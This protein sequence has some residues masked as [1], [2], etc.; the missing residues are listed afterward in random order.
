MASLVTAAPPAT[1]ASSSSLGDAIAGNGDVSQLFTTL[2]VAQIRNQ[3]PLE[4]TDPS[5]F[6]AQL[7]QLS[8]VETMHAMASQTTRNGALL[9]SLQTLGLGGQVGSTVTATTDRVRLGDTPV[10][11]SFEL[12]AT[13]AKTTLVLTAANGSERRIEL[14]TRSAGS[15]AF[16]LDRS[17]LGLA[18]GPYALRVEAENGS[19]GAVSVRGTLAGVRLAADGSVVV[20]VDAIGTTQPDAITAFH[21]RATATTP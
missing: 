8:Q 5:Q 11:G 20:D 3:N 12:A 19:A 21:G 16:S 4:P 2:L 13:S 6:V 18:A 17:A 9:E 1:T 14:G 10:A 7:T 15:V